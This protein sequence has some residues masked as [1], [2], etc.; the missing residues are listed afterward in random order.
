MRRRAGT[1]IPNNTYGWGRINVQAAVDM[2]RQ[3]G[4]LRGSVTDAGTG[5]PIAGATVSI[6]R[7][8]YTLTQATDAAGT[9]SFVA[10]AGAYQVKTEA[11]GYAPQTVSSVSVGEGAATT[12]DFAL[13]RL[14]VGS[15]AGFVLENGDPA[16]PVQVGVL[17]VLPVSAGLSA[18]V[19][20]DGTY[21]LAGVPSGLRTVRLRAPGYATQTLDVN[22]N[23][24]MMLD[25][26]P[27]PITDY[28]LNVS[29]DGGAC[30]VAHVWIDATDG[31]D[32]TAGL[33]DDSS[34]SVAL[35]A[36]FTFYGGVYST[37][38]VASNGLLSFGAGYG[39]LNSVIP[40]VGAPNNAIYAFADDLNPANGNQ[41]KVYTK[42]VDGRLVIEF[43]QV[44]HSP[45]GDPETFEIVLDPAD[46][47]I[48]VQYQTVSQAN[49]A[50]VGVENADGSRALRYSYA[51][52][53]P[54]TPG[55]AVKFTPFTGEPP[56][57]A[58]PA[59][60]LVEPVLNGATF[61]VQWQDVA[62]NQGYE[63]WRDP[64]PY[65]DPPQGVRLAAVSP[66]VMSYPDTRPSGEPPANRFYLVRGLFAGVPSGP[67]DRVG[68][69]VFNLE[70]G[71]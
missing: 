51:N 18:T 25:F 39:S 63:I 58:R 4:T 53:P 41:G 27:A 22:V 64:A 35:P 45:N 57:C 50:L 14:A 34:V 6:T 28:A 30:S 16:K 54:I 1:Q 42:T 37:V 70:P 40:F 66:G 49:N 5:L 62:P 15:V 61:E 2:V 46:D 69:F 21:H 12:Q 44:Q 56:A 17:E 8:G 7:N 67:S 20:A 48:L 71:N 38:Y 33:G 26:A 3:A 10:G 19:A 13:S 60:P 23:G 29:S 55:L 24:A 68:E 59:A 11:F 47:S 9:Y 32:I 31:T 65:F 52:Q 36:A 43:A